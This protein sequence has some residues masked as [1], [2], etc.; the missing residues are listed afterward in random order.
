MLADI[1]TGEVDLADL[2]FLVAFI[3]LVVAAIWSWAETH[4]MVTTLM[5]VGGA[6]IAFGL[7]AL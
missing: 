3:V 7:M 1:M 6:A 5:C 4:S 2:A